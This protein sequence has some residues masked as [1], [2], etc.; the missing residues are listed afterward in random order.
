MLDFELFKG[1]AGSSVAALSE[2]Y[3]SVM[4]EIT[5]VEQA[6]GDRPDN[7]FSVLFKGPAEPF[8]EQMTHEITLGDHGNHAIFLVPINEQ[9]D[10]YVY[11]AVF[12]AF[13]E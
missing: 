5:E 1:L 12:T 13:N 9:S 4:L 11:E 3:G 2:E 6:A 7:A 10:G 8:L